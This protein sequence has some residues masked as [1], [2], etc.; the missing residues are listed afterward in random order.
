MR[1]GEQW[2]GVRALQGGP[3][4]QRHARR[5]LPHDEKRL[6]AKRSSELHAHTTASHPAA[7]QA[8]GGSGHLPPE[9]RHQDLNTPQLPPTSII[10]QPQS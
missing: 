1:A 10:S 9:T 8:M 7:H 3:H 5:L 2:L 4:A 6:V